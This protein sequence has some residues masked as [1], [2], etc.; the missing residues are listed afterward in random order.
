MDG[1]NSGVDEPCSVTITVN[2]FSNIIPSD[3]VDGE[4]SQI[5]MTDDP[6]TASTTSTDLLNECVL[7]ETTNVDDIIA[8]F[9]EIDVD[10]FS[11]GFYTTDNPG[12]DTLP[13]PVADA[14]MFQANEKISKVLNESCSFDSIN[15]AQVLKHRLRTLEIEKLA[16]MV[17]HNNLIREFNDSV[18]SH[19]EEIRNLNE[20]NEN[21]DRE[22]HELR[23]LTC[24][25]D[26]ERNKYK[27]M[28]KEW[29]KFGR[30]MVAVVRTEMA[31]YQKKM[32]A[33]E[34]KQK[35]LISE[36]IELKD[37]CVHLDRQ[38]STKEPND[39]SI[40]LIV[41][42]ECSALETP[43]SSNKWKSSSKM[44][45]SSD[46]HRQATPNG[47]DAS[48]KYPMKEE[49]QGLGSL[50]REKDELRKLLLFRGD[51]RTEK[52]KVKFDFPDDSDSSTTSDAD[53]SEFPTRL[54]DLDRKTKLG[55][56]FPLTN[57]SDGDV[58]PSNEDCTPPPK[59]NILKKFDEE[60]LS[61]DH[62]FFPTSPKKSLGKSQDSFEEDSGTRIEQLKCEFNDSGTAPFRTKTK[63]N[64]EYSK[65][66]KGKLKVNNSIATNAISN[67]FGKSFNE[68]PFDEVD[69][70]Q[71]YI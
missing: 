50:E 9:N 54:S 44:K 27:K 34:K 18:E 10:Q 42:S 15:D 24:F 51:N 47:S 67:I 68:D 69:K 37:L 7:S 66:S 16:L 21:Y 52:K 46:K 36:N 29:Q 30:H 35:S 12:T 63:S 61:S 59:A 62:L 4:N 53:A 60:N 5:N 40:K 70:N 65:Q 1:N 48:Q 58:T 11:G 57:I 38:R 14:Q 22:I 64:G 71:E 8:I 19:L 39:S 43:K 13:P 6:V 23:D 17:D 32:M 28:A 41:C 33:F 2:K 55:K 25:L 31:S 45:H 3:F 49:P 20:L 56:T 26:D